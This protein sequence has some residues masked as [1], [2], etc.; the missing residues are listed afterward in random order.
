M[1][2][3]A[4]VFIDKHT[5]SSVPDLHILYAVEV[6]LDDGTKYEVLRR[7]SEFSALHDALDDPYALPPKNSVFNA[8][9]PSAWAND[10]LITESKDRL[11]AYLNSLLRSS[12]YQ[13]SSKLLAFLN[14]NYITDVQGFDDEITPSMICKA[15][16]TIKAPV[17]SLSSLVAAAYYPDWSSWSNPPSKMDFSKFDILF[18][19]FVVPNSSSTINW[20]DGSQD[21]LRNLVSAACQ[22]GHRT[23]IVLSIGGWGGSYWFS[24]SMSNA[25]NRTKLINALVGAVNSFGLDGI[26]ID[27][28]YPNSPGSGNPYSWADATNFLTF[29]KCLRAALGWSKIISA[30][31]A[32]HPWL[33]PSGA[34]LSNVSD[35]AA[36]MSYINIMNYDVNGASA[37]PAPNAPLGNLCGSSS[38][39]EANAQAALTQWKEAGFPPSKMLLGLALYGYV[40]KSTATRLSNSYAPVAELHEHAPL[41]ERTDTVAGDLSQWWGSQVAFKQLVSAGALKKQADGTYGGTN[42]FTMGWDDCSDTPFL[43]NTAKTTVV[44]YDDT[45]SLADK[46]KFAKQS[47]MA[48]CFTWSL[49]QDDEYSLQNVIRSN[50]GK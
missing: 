39:P 37:T 41:V 5:T 14:L 15:N 47:G 35:Y 50:L 17:S 32:H 16:L 9:V 20:D 48:G 43:Y 36:Q 3:I 42:G 8:L 24:N 34:P 27:W 29:L 45:Y 13:S 1:S 4:N 38:Q 21:T 31:V 33:G 26:D 2:S 46:A 6:V 40:S 23:Q 30:A 25:T 22:S 18:F 11:L 28:E 49:D 10:E 12:L 44:S 19:A 7:Y